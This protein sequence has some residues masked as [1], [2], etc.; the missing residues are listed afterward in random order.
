M[1]V[2]FFLSLLCIATYGRLLLL[3]ADSKISHCTRVFAL[4]LLLC[5]RLRRHRCCVASCSRFQGL[6]RICHV[7][8]KALHGNTVLLLSRRMCLLQTCVFVA[9]RLFAGLLR[10]QPLSNNIILSG[11]ASYS[12]NKNKQKQD[13]LQF[14]NLT[15]PAIKLLPHFVLLLRGCRL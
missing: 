1:S 13:L 14:G 15:V 6:A 8:L 12:K 7:A 11:I 9:Q 5:L 10:S 2:L 3:S 4:L